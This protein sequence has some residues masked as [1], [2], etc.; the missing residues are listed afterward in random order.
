[1]Q[2]VKWIAMPNVDADDN[3]DIDEYDGTLSSVGVVRRKDK[4]GTVGVGI[5]LGTSGRHQRRQVHSCWEILILRGETTRVKPHEMHSR[6]G[7]AFWALDQLEL[8]EFAGEGEERSSPWLTRLGL[9]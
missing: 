6:V 3:R 2:M 4:R 1:M 7:R 9:D 5:D 8:L